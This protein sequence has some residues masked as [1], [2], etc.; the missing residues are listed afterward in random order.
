[1]TC[2]EFPKLMSAQVDGY[3]TE[4]EQVALQSHL[5]ECAACRRYAADLRNLRSDLRALETPQPAS[6]LGL[7]PAF[8]GTALT[9]QIQMALRRQA[10]IVKA[11][12][13]RREDLRD[14]WLMRLYSQGLATAV[15]FALLLFVVAAIFRPAY[16]TL[17]LFDAARQVAFEP[18]ILDDPSIRFRVLLAQ[19]PPPPMFSPDQ[20]LLE[21]GEGMPADTEIIATVKVNHRNGRAQLDY[22]VSPNDAATE[23]AMLTDR[24]ATAFHDH[25]SFQLPDARSRASSENAVILF[26]KVTISAQLD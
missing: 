3:A 1:M 10:P 18:E 13:R 22:V 17:A 4:R 16:R 15:S 19:P 12:T 26:G 25:A 23:D 7:E 11:E 5:R 14:W 8:G 2:S 9:A 20:A 24:L 6:M 21:L